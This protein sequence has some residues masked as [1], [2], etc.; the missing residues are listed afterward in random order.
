M[1][2][3]ASRAVVNAYQ[4]DGPDDLNQLLGT[5]AN[6][7]VWDSPSAL[8][9]PAAQQFDFFQP[10]L[11]DDTF[12]SLD[13][14]L[15]LSG[16]IGRVIL[17]LS[18]ASGV[19]MDVLV[20]LYAD[21]GGQPTGAP[22]TQ[23]FVPKEAQTTPL[24]ASVIQS[25]PAFYG[26][27]M[28]GSWTPQASLPTPIT[29]AGLVSDGQTLISIGGSTGTAATANVY[30]A[31][32]S[33]D[34]NGNPLVGTWSNT[35]ALP[36]ARVAPGVAVDGETVIVVG[37]WDDNATLFSDVWSGTITNGGVSSWVAGTSLPTA[38][39]GVSVAILNGYVYAIGGA[40]SSTSFT[41]TVYYAPLNDGQVGAWVATTAFPTASGFM[42]AAVVDDTIFVGD[43]G[44]AFAVPSAADGSVNEWT[45]LPANSAAAVTQ[46]ASCVVGDTLYEISGLHLGGGTAGSYSLTLSDNPATHGIDDWIPSWSAQSQLPVSVYGASATSA[47]DMLVTAGGTLAGTTNDPQF[48]R[49]A[50]AS[51]GAT[52]QATLPVTIS[53]TAGDTL[54]LCVAYPA[55]LTIVDTA[56]NNWILVASSF[57]SAIYACPNSLAI[58]SVQAQ[59][60]A[61]TL[62]QFTSTCI[63]V[64]GAIA[65]SISDVTATGGSGGASSSPWSYQIGPFSAVGDFLIAFNVG[66]N[67]TGTNPTT[68]AA[69]SPPGQTALAIQAFNYT[70]G[71]FTIGEGTFVSYGSLVSNDRVTYTGSMT[72]VNSAGARVITLMVAVKPASFTSDN[73]YATT[74]KRVPSVSVPLVA[75]G[76]SGNYHVVVT[77]VGTFDNKN[78]SQVALS[79]VNPTGASPVANELEGKGSSWQATNDYIPLSVYSTGTSTRLVHTVTTLQEWSWMSYNSTGQPVQILES[80]LPLINLLPG[81]TSTL[82]GSVQGTTSGW[83]PTN[84]A[85]TVVALT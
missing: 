33:L 47:Q 72:N 28:L 16:G 68:P 35:T 19:G 20:G 75:T 12:I 15:S 70:A 65:T 62:A 27:P 32:I 2:T 67:Q 37:G 31:S 53:T 29:N 54:F 11:F 74:T 59:L 51:T 25:T 24:D 46:P 23:T 42:A 4:G 10:L 50:Q 73:V 18:I 63:E 40:T 78:V 13:Q 6:T 66:T 17:P 3:P 57:E 39:F 58:T 48:V 71:L 85:L 79:S 61:G 7:Q 80:T 36:G 34:V 21:N 9:T 45:P 76:L 26:Q 84:A 56:Q 49:S 52:A 14:P 1:T 44:F 43:T 55:P 77:P 81:N 8:S 82:G 22:I 30:A 60:P 38:L 83:T 64:S 69:T 5:Q 41:N